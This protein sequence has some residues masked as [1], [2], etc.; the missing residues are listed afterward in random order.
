M[1]CLYC[2]RNAREPAGRRRYDREGNGDENDVT[3]LAKHLRS[4]W[5]LR[6][7]QAGMPVL[8]EGDGETTAVRKGMAKR[9][10]VV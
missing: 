8:L 6:L 3:V 5:V 9:N 2:W 10:D 7:A 4:R 1:P